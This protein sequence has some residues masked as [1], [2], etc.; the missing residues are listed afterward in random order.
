MTDART[1]RRL[2]P[3]VRSVA[4]SRVRCA[5]VIENVLKMTK[6]PTKSAMPPNASSSFWTIA[7]CLSLPLASAFTLAAPVA[8][9]PPAGTSGW[10]V[11]TSC[12]G[13]TPSFARHPDLVEP[14][15]LPEERL[16]GRDVEDR[17]R[18][19]ADR[20]EAGELAR[21]R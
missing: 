3:S 12:S 16:R 4:S 11:R 7:T 13:E 2:A 8:T 1:W 21:R 5:I 15:G 14:A 6:A 18:Q 19:L 10:S 20:V 9:S 17:E